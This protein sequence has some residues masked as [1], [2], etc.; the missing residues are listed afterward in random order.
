MRVDL[1]VTQKSDRFGFLSGLDTL[2]NFSEYDEPSLEQALKVAKWTIN[3]IQDNDGHFY[4]RQYPFIKAKTPMLH[5]G[6]AAMYRGLTS[7]VVTNKLI[8]ARGWE[9]CFGSIYLTYKKGTDGPWMITKFCA[10]E[11]A[12]SEL[13]QLD[14]LYRNLAGISAVTGPTGSI[15][16]Q[17]H[18]PNQEGLEL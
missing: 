18:P 10:A 12:G 17:V 14:P 7:P 16:G 1:K 3:N 6:Q 5:W 8:R 11:G 9:S 2:A 13:G 4:Y 15:G